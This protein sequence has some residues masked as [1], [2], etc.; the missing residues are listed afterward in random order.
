MWVEGG[1]LG[2]GRRKERKPGKCMK[3]KEVRERSG[4][5]EKRKDKKEEERSE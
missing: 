2:R 3:R 4:G 1:T 5:Q